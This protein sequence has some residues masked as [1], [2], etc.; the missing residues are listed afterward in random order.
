MEAYLYWAKAIPLSAREVQAQLQL[1]PEQ[2]RRRLLQLRS[3]ERL[4]AA[5]LAERLLRHGMKEQYGI[6]MDPH[7]RKVTP[8]GKPY[9]AEEDLFFSLSH[10]GSY[11]LAALSKQP[12]GAD[13]QVEKQADFP[14]I[15][16]RM[17]AA[18]EIEALYKEREG[19]AQRRLFFQIWTCRESMGKQRGCGMIK[20]LPACISQQGR[21][22]RR[23]FHFCNEGI[24]IAA[25]GADQEEC[26]LQYVDFAPIDTAKE[27][28]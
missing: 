25:Y 6:A 12:I 16:R 10:S 9:F 17:F 22:D 24:H 13:I 3:E 5:L 23:C 28:V 11:A 2:K 20:A 21:L 8:Q 4:Y 7:K 14:A 18:E 26:H 19:A 1:L 27:F 15:A